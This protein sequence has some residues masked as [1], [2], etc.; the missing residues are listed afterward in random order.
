MKKIFNYF[1][2]SGANDLY[3]QLRTNAMI[4]LCLFG[5][6]SSWLLI[7]VIF[8]SKTAGEG[9]AVL[10]LIM[11]ST[12][13]IASLF[14]LKYFGISKAGNIFS[15]GAVILL[16]ATLNIIPD[17]KDVL[18]KFMEGFYVIQMVLVLGVLLA[19]NVTILIASLLIIGTTIR[20]YVVGVDAMP[21][22]AIEMKKALMTH[23]FST[24]TITA[25]LLAT[26]SFTV[27]SI[28]KAKMDA[29]IKEEQNQKLNKVFGLL[30]ETSDVLNS[31]SAEIEGNAYSLNNNSAEQAS[32]IEEISATVEEI[33][34]L[35]VNNS[36]QTEQSS[37]VV[38]QTNDFVQQSG[39][40]I[41]N[42]KAAIK[43]ISEKT[44]FIKDIAFQTNILAL[45]AAIEAARAGEA[46]KGFSVVAQEVKK[47]A[48]LSDNGARE[49]TEMVSEA[50]VDSDK[51]ENYQDT[52]VKDIR[53]I[54]EV[55][56]NVS[57]SS[58]EQKTGAEQI[59]LTISEVNTGAQRNASISEKLNNTVKLL[60]ENAHKLNQLLEKQ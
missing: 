8:L 53:R 39:E 55:M 14:A 16:I 33:T 44:D 29:Q 47:L 26:R 58:H 35:I 23:V 27:R 56:D 18:Y 2:P 22:F 48:E 10:A 15:M 51:A 31:L 60:T 36:D 54:K 9:N 50:I 57:S 24:V 32:N 43:K 34:S 41:S 5:F 4:A 7:I 45:N 6:V 59:N 49:I 19:S 17:N 40:I 30:T 42:T 11:L 1:R 37:I 38:N 3:D 20:I 28:R 46:G 25:I 13:M 21:E 52:I 12:F